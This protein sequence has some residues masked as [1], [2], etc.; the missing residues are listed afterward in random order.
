LKS[1][2]LRWALGAACAATAVINPRAALS[3]DHGDPP[4]AATEPGAN[5]ND[6][7]T[8]M[9]GAGTNVIFVMDVYGAGA[10]IGA[11]FS[12]NIQYLFE[13]SSAATFGP[14]TNP[15]NIVCTFNIAQK[16]QCWAGTDEYVT[17]DASVAGGITSKSGKFKVYAG[18]RADPFYLN[19]NGFKDMVGTIKQDID[20]GA[21][22]LDPTGC[23]NVSPAQ[24][25]I[26]VNKLKG[27]PDAA[28]L[29]VVEDQFKLLNT[30][31]IVVQIDKALVTKG[32]PLIAASAS[33]RRVP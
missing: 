8:F 4:I 11:K 12:D 29:G 6:L 17:G 27:H 16:I 26:L 20:S 21:L 1:R 15:V 18:L 32:G 14:T 13:T 3:A 33:T 7:Y 30:L 9:D 10:P 28:A 31:A 5:V 19:S 25:T 24:S 22:T 2:L 23:P